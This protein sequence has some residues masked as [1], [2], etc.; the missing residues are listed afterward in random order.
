MAT[1]SGLFVS[2]GKGSGLSTPVERARAVAGHGFEGCGHAGR[3]R[4]EVLFA[5]AEHLEALGVESGAIRENVTVAGADVQA[6]EIGQ[7]VRAGGAVFEITMVCE[8]CHKMDAL[9]E[10]LRA[11]LDGKRG[12]LAVV[13]ESGEVA[14][15]DELLP[16]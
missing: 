6:W 7:R 12:M 14:L 11:Q 2:P 13:V 15:G 3:E 4:R 10:G 1:V 16:L 5:S 8:P 9:R